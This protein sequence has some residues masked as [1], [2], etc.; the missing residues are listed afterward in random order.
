MK[1][2]ILMILL[3]LSLALAAGC[4]GGSG[5]NGDNN[6]PVETKFWD[7]DGT[8][9][10]QFYTNDLDNCNKG[11]WLAYNTDYD[12]MDTVE[13]EVKK[14][15][16]SELYPFGIIFC[17]EKTN[18]EIHYYRLLIWIDGSYTL[19]KV[20]TNTLTETTTDMIIPDSN[21]HADP[22][23]L[24]PYV[25]HN[26]LNKGHN[27]VNSIKVV[28]S[29]TGI[30]DIYFNSE[31]HPT[32]AATFSDTS[33]PGGKYGFYAAVGEP[34]KEKFPNT[35]VDVRFRQNIPDPSVAPQ[36]SAIKNQSVQPGMV[37]G[38]EKLR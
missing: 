5:G 9:F 24:L 28:R 21:N 1:R 16:G 36:T 4:G 10:S 15:F 29:E 12:R 23:N 20:V 7:D 11:F 3:M 34:S 30:F 14:V 31:E 2:F 27:V 18:S 22:D 32:P 17:F 6:L 38:S 35:P 37:W 8:G 13:T 19:R 26:W 33:Y 25:P